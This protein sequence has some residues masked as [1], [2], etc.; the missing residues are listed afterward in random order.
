MGT[1]KASGETGGV[2]EERRSG[3]AEGRRG[4]GASDAVLVSS[5]G[6]RLGIVR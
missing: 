4:G 6:L 1:V 5:L 2:A 3:G